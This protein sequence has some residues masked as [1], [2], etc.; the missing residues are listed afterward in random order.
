M[1]RTARKALNEI[2][3]ETFKTGGRRNVIKEDQLCLQ[4]QEI[5]GPTAAPMKN[6]FDDDG[7][8]DEVTG[9]FG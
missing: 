7:L 3:Q 4:I 5:I 1:K 8:S 9:C 6:A 2:H